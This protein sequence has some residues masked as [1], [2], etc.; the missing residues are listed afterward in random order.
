M[1]VGLPSTPRRPELRRP[2]ARRTAARDAGADR[3]RTVS[4]PIKWINGHR[5][6]PGAMDQPSSGR[7]RLGI[8]WPSNMP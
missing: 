5:G 6:S 7:G 2:R 1:N 3:L 4:P 8:I